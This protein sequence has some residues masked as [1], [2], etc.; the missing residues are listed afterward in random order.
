[1]AE[2]YRSQK[3]KVSEGVVQV[4]SAELP[5]KPIAAAG[6]SCSESVRGRQAIAVAAA[7]GI[8]GARQAHL[9]EP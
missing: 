9:Q 4:Q 2:A 8:Q 5:N 6:G 3:S 7:A 1:M